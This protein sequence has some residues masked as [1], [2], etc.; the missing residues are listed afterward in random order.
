MAST[1]AILLIFLLSV[2]STTFVF[3]CQGKQLVVEVKDAPK[4]PKLKQTQL[5]FYI[6]ENFT[7]PDPTG[8]PIA[9]AAST[10]SSATQFG[11]TYVFDHPL[12]LDPETTVD[13][14]GRA[15][16]IFSLTSKEIVSTTVLIT[17]IF[18]EER[19][20]GSTLVVS[21]RV[22]SGDGRKELPVIGGSGA[23]RFATGYC[24]IKPY[25]IGGG[26]ELP[27]Y[28]IYVRHYY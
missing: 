24:D 19:F 2:S 11:L 23:F 21:G 17:F 16:G 22:E 27:F 9:Q 8:V 6:K 5:Q 7:G 14:V 10:N 28:N 12:T 13:V 3:L 25:D 15:Q 1:T 20:N 26:L 18:N 4:L